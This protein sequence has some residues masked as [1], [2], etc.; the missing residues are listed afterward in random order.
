MKK[1]FESLMNGT[2][3]NLIKLDYKKYINEREN[4]KYLLNSL[5]LAKTIHRDKFHC[6]KFEDFLKPF[7][8]IHLSYCNKK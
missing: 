7:E 3:K 5:E 2:S 1:L 6:L 4:L 8:T